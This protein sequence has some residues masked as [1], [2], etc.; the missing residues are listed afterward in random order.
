VRATH[1]RRCT[2]GTTKLLLLVLLLLLLLQGA[3]PQT[4]TQSVASGS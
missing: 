1:R 4:S 3:A 2:I